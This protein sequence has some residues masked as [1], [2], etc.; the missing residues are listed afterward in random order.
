TNYLRILHGATGILLL[1]LHLPS[2]AT[3]GALTLAYAAVAAALLLAGFLRPDRFSRLAALGLFLFCLAKL[4][5]YDF[6]ELD[7]ASRIL[8]FI[9]LGLLLIG[10][11]WIYS[12]FKQQ[13]RRLL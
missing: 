1:C 12:R 5:L 3:K 7:T 2:A 13:I 8:S 10:A 4:F 11:S 9:G 6:R